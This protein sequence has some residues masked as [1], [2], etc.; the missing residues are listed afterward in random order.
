MA[1]KP[2]SLTG[3]EFDI[4]ALLCAHPSE[5][6]SPTEIYNQV[7]KMPDLDATHTVQV[8]ISHLRRKLDTNCPEHKFIQTAWGKGYY[9]V[10]SP[11]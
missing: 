5:V 6:L 7:W 1:G 10:P 8:H 4:L 11:D 2:L 9:F 3:G